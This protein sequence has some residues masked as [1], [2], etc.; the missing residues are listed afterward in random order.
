MDWH[1]VTTLTLAGIVRGRC[2][3]TRSLA[4]STRTGRRTGARSPL[5]LPSARPALS[6]L[7]R[8]CRPLLT[9][10]PMDRDSP[11]QQA[12]R[13]P[14]RAGHAASALYYDAVS[15]TGGSAHLSS[16]AVGFGLL[17]LCFA[18]KLDRMTPASAA[19]LLQE[20]HV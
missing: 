17:G 20:T 16:A 18:A 8:L 10:Q 14:S 2:G 7:W 19:A 3:S 5:S 12:F 6:G 15:A 9:Q 13:V 11:A 4:A 1:N